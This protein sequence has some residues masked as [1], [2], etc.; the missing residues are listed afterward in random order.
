MP[1][2]LQRVARGLVECL[3]EVPQVLHHLQRTAARCRESAALAAQ[4]GA[5]VAA[6]QLDAAA[7][8]CEAAA[9]Y[10]SMAPPKARAWADRLVGGGSGTDRPSSDS[11]ERNPFAGSSPRP[12][13]VNDRAADREGSGPGAGRGGD[14]KDG[15]APPP[16]GD[17]IDD[18]EPTRGPSSSGQEP[19][20]RT[21]ST[22][23][24]PA[25]FFGNIFKLLPGRPGGKGPTSGI[26]ATPD[27]T[28]LKRVVSGTQ[29]PGAGA[30]G[31]KGKTARLR[32]AR[33]DAEGHA[34]AIMRRL[35]A[36]ELTLYLNNEP[37]GRGR[38]DVLPLSCDA[39]LKY[40]IPPGSKLTVY[41]PGGRQVYIGE[42]G[43][44]G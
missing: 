23:R 33:V 29:G 41:W 27:G 37:C 2:D 4:G 36:R 15:G 8:A 7:R 5:T 16:R 44:P 43:E 10:L 9:H 24:V 11:A 18:S 34:A 32:V 22:D 30:P 38:N 26:L 14:G 6:H 42:E 13:D 20:K 28:P 40:Q 17:A 35:R 39:T 3:D 25:P 19:H 21:D 12:V 31:L 1:S